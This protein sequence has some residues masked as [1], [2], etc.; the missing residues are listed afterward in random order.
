M[1]GSREPPGE[2]NSERG[3]LTAS[4]AAELRPTLRADDVGQWACQGLHSLFLRIHLRELHNML[5]AQARVSTAV[6]R[7]LPAAHERAHFD[8]PSR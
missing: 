4:R 6:R 3:R 8:I 2:C 7:L 5:P 1:V